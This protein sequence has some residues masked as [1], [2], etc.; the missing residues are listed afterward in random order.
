MKVLFF[1]PIRKELEVLKVTIPSWLKLESDGLEIKYVFFDDNDSKQSRQFIKSLAENN[2]S[3]EIVSFNTI[4]NDNYQGDHNWNVKQIDRISEIKNYALNRCVQE[5]FNAVFLVDA[6]LVLHPL[7]LQSLIK[8]KKD[9]IF[10]IFWTDFQKNGNFR[11]N[12]WDYHS[13][14]Y[15]NANSILKL[16]SK[17]IHKVGAGGACTLVSKEL[18]DKGLNFDR[19]PNM[20]FNGEDRHISTRVYSLNSEVFIDT[21]YPAYHIHDIKKVTE[22]K[23]WYNSGSKREFFDAWLNDSWEEQVK[24]FYKP[25]TS[26]IIK[27]KRAIYLGRR[28]FINALK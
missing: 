27:L 2:S 17:G 16:K 10:E 28:A 9:F 13:W 14:Q 3:I 26:K 23:E 24:M 18:I 5:N 1:T 6:D 11:P 19:I 21:H 22:A 15:D 25:V 7:T 12:C 4:V 20:R 8:A